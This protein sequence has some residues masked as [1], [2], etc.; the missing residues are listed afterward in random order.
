MRDGRS[1]PA[2][3]SQRSC[4]PCQTP[5][6]RRSRDRGVVNRKHLESQLKP[7]GLNLSAPPSSL[8]NKA[9]GKVNVAVLVTG[10]INQQ[11]G[12]IIAIVRVEG[13]KTKAG[14]GMMFQGATEAELVEQMATSLPTRIAQVEA[15]FAAFPQ[16]Q[17]VR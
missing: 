12:S 10:V 11:Q 17:P 13:L 15:N 1:A 8:A 6:R 3:F 9:R 4:T 2:R 7:L 5:H 16:G 14:I